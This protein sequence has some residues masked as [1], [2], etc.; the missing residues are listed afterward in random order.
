[1]HAGVWA[2]ALIATQPKTKK[3]KPANALENF[4]KAPIYLNL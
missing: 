1:V 2:L 3:L 4:I